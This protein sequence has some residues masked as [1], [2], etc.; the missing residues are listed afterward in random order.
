MIAEMDRAL[1]RCS[2]IYSREACR[3]AYHR[4]MKAER[5]VISQR[6]GF[7]GELWAQIR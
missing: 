6:H 3:N 5:D 1:E 4:L 7:P 2:D